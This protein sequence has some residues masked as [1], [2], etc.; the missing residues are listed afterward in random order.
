MKFKDFQSQNESFADIVDKVKGW[1]G[2]E[3]R[4]ERIK[5]LAQEYLKADARNTFYKVA[6]RIMEFSDWAEETYRKV[7]KIAVDLGLEEYGKASIY[8]KVPKAIQR[9][10][11]LFVARGGYG[12]LDPFDAEYADAEGREEELT[13]GL[14]DWFR[15]GKVELGIIFSFKCKDFS[16]A[17][18]L[19]LRINKEIPREIRGNSQGLDMN[20]YTRQD[21]ITDPYKESLFITIKLYNG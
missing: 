18:K 15:P 1:L 4:A 20:R 5:R 9:E 8:T 21:V 10:I 14:K 17:E 2:L 13:K 3:T 6:D 16:K 7:Q 19:R 11:D 12:E